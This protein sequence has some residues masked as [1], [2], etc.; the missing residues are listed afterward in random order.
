MRRT[1]FSTS[2]VQP[3][4]ATE[5]SDNGLTRRNFTCL[6]L[7]VE[8]EEPARFRNWQ[9]NGILA[10][11]RHWDVGDGEP[12]CLKSKIGRGLQLV[13]GGHDQSCSSSKL[14]HRH[15]RPS[16]F[17][18]PKYRYVASCGISQVLPPPQPVINT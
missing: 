6:S 2:S 17:E 10:V 7:A 12:T 18:Q 1:M 4:W 16:A 3:R 14:V 9:R 5:I 13:I 15:Q 8:A 11:Q